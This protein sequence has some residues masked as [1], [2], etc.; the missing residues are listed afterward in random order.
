MG[1]KLE[2]RNQEFN[3]L[4]QSVGALKEFLNEIPNH[5]KYKID[6]RD[7]SMFFNT[8]WI[9]VNETVEEEKLD[10]YTIVLPHICVYG[11][12]AHDLI[13]DL[14]PVDNTPFKLIA[15]ETIE[16]SK[17]FV[18]ILMHNISNSNAPYVIFEG[19]VK[20][21]FAI[22]EEAAYRYRVPLQD[23]EGNNFL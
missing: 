13:T 15:T 17:G 4:P 1:K 21:H 5:A 23:S 2:V 14:N 18:H 19:W 12:L 16:L 11:K 8:Y 6:S 20:E 10:T 3:L 7:G 9:G 22:L